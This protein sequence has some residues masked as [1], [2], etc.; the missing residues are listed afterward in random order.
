MLI[1]MLLEAAPSPFPF[2]KHLARLMLFEEHADVVDTKYPAP[3]A[4]AKGPQPSIPERKID[5]MRRAVF[6]RRI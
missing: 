2:L 4:Y 5:D 6:F 3:L 1:L